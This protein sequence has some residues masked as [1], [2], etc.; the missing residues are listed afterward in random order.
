MQ[1]DNTN[2]RKLSVFTYFL[3]LSCVVAIT[4]LFVKELNISPGFEE[5]LYQKDIESNVELENRY[6]IKKIKEEYGINITFGE[7]EKSFLTSVDASVQN[8]I[9]IVNNNLKTIYSALQKYP[10]DVFDIFKDEKYSLYILLVSHF[11]DNNIALASK[12]TLNQY[13]IYLSNDE[14]FERAFHHEFFHILEYYMADRTK[15]LYN[16]WNSYNPIGF[17]YESNI[18][19]LTDQYVYNNYLTDEENKD[20]YFV[21]KYAKTSAKED[22]AEIFA[23]IMTLNKNVSYLKN[24]NKLREK[25]DYLLNE[26]YENISISDFHF[27]SYIN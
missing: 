5:I 10:D 20:A 27:S 7:S 2:A 8:D 25:V 16:S 3:I 6:Y 26:V 15:Y 11:N 18:S 19:R 22:R 21:S 24:G 9:N 14:K 17:K 23:E 1:K 4:I 13:R 12:N